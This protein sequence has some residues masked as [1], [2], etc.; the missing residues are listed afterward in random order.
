MFTEGSVLDERYTLLHCLGRGK[1]GEVWKARNRDGT[2]VAVKCTQFD[3]KLTEQELRAVQAVKNIKHPNLTP[4]NE[5]WLEN[6]SG[7]KIPEQLDSDQ[8]GD[9]LGQDLNLFIVMQLAEKSLQDRFEE[10][11]SQ[12]LQGVPRDELIPSFR[13]AARA[14]DYLNTPTHAVGD[15]HNVAIHHCDVKPANIL[16]YHGAAQVC[17]FS[18]VRVWDPDGV[19]GS[20]K[21][22]TPAYAA[23]ECLFEGK[24]T[25]AADQYSLAI[26]Y[27][28][29]VG[30]KPAFPKEPY[31]EFLKARLENRLNL[32]ALTSHEQTIIEKAASRDPDNRFASA[33]EL[34]ETLAFVAAKPRFQ[35]DAPNGVSLKVLDGP[36][37]GRHLPIARS[38]VT[39]GRSQI[40]DLVMGD[41]EVS[42]MHCC[43]RVLEEDL[44]LKDLGSANG[45]F[46]NG[47]ETTGE[48]S[49]SSGDV[50][51]VGNERMEVHWVD[52]GVLH[53]VP[54]SDDSSDSRTGVAG[55]MLLTRMLTDAVAE[56]RG[57]HPEVPASVIAQVLQRVG[58]EVV[59]N[60]VSS[61]PPVAGIP[62]RDA[63]HAVISTF[64]SQHPN[65]LSDAG[66]AETIREVRQAFQ[67]ATTM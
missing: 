11:K 40:C 61:P 16:L 37:Q 48:S 54:A 60:V 31:G 32:T 51:Q 34:V 12:G 62:L 56:F 8:A 6:L 64:Q 10:C 19:Q 59:P 35:A 42:R 7:E 22:V 58:G 27:V 14:I 17:D 18:L 39:I 38:F 45:T 49:L 3:D 53:D 63:V 23:P 28:E 33:A 15:S 30:G 29:L 50:L 13:D 20:P 41:Q 36:N 9:F 2:L 26:S 21:G 65:I 66:L 44:V 24:S 25:R 52:G 1:F 67:A 4:V 57:E 5:F 43:L 55:K 46:V 47:Q